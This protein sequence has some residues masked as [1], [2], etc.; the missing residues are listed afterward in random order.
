[1]SL[2]MIATNSEPL[3]IDTRIAYL[4]NAQVSDN[5]VL[6]PRCRTP[7]PQGCITFLVALRE[8]VWHKH[9]WEVLRYSKEKHWVGTERVLGVPHGCARLKCYAT[10]A[11]YFALQIWKGKECVWCRSLGDR[12]VF[13]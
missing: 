10:I 13:Q 9:V 11:Q 6:P 7:L 3:G 8:R 2:S 4:R 5:V 1:M 12:K